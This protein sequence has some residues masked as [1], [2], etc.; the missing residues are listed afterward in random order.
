MIVI[1]I[2]KSNK[3][4]MINGVKDEINSAL[5][6]MTPLFNSETDEIKLM[7]YSNESD[8]IKL[9]YEVLRNVKRAKPD[10]DLES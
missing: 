9:S 6:K 8:R 10:E 2:K 4:K 1:E 3:T 7:K 5:Q